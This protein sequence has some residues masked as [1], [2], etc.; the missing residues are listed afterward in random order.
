MPPF[1]GQGLNSG[2]R[3][4][5]AL[6]WRL[7]MVCK[8]QAQVKI[9]KS[10]CLERRKQVDFI[11]EQCISLGRPICL[12]DPE[13]A[14]KVVSDGACQV[15]LL[16]CFCFPTLSTDRCEL[17]SLPMGVKRI[18]SFVLLWWVGDFL[19][20][21]PRA[22]ILLYVEEVCNPNSTWNSCGKLYFVPTNPVILV[23]RLTF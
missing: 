15:A 23:F 4:A 2:I 16:N 20:R 14:E 19:M 18:P 8:A 1:I 6:A 7:A 5:A 11:M 13:T 9:M 21:V 17:N 12:T 3:D 22:E 10:F